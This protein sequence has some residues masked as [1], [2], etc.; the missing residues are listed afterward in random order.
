MGHWCRWNTV[1]WLS[2]NQFCAFARFELN[3]HSSSSHTGYF[4]KPGCKVQDRPWFRQRAAKNC[5]CSWAGR[6]NI[7]HRWVGPAWCPGINLNTH[8]CLIVTLSLTADRPKAQWGKSQHLFFLAGNKLCLMSW[9][10]FTNSYWIVN[11]SR[12]STATSN[13]AKLSCVVSTIRFTRPQKQVLLAAQN[14]IKSVSCP[15]YRPTSM[16]RLRRKTLI[17]D[18][19]NKI[20]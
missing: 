14:M 10:I 4:G 2:A 1:D 7:W 20:K 17:F 3:S 15:Q 11:K 8:S 19:K 18:A 12:W 13:F 6:W 9:D 5:H 16:W